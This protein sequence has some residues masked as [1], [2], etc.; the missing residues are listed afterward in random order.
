MR[1]R[2]CCSRASCPSSSPSCSP[3][4]SEPPSTPCASTQFSSCTCC[5]PRGQGQGKGAGGGYTQA[6]GSQAG[7]RR[8][9]AGWCRGLTTYMACLETDYTLHSE[10]VHALLACLGSPRRTPCPPPGPQGT[11]PTCSPGPSRGLPSSWLPSRGT[12]GVPA[13]SG[14]T[15]NASGVP[16]G[17]EDSA[18]SARGCQLQQYQR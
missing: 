8:A 9:D 4:T 7:R 16:M 1:G 3:T 11:W 18:H 17:H 12:S 10:F 13:N 15:G 14:I 5:C 2:R 6:R